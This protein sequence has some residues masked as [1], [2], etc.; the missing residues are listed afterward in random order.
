MGFYC[1]IYIAARLSQ[2]DGKAHVND[3]VVPKEYRRF[4]DE[5]GCWYRAYMCRDKWHDSVQSVHD[6]FPTWRQVQEEFPEE[7]K[8]EYGWSKEDHDLFYKALTW[9][10]QQ[11]TRFI[12]E[13]G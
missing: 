13:W 7:T 12:V 8:N 6:N 11:S 2:N 1:Q 9:F 10:S 3:I 4:V 5:K